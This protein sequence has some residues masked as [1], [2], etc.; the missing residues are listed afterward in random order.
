MSNKQISELLKKVASAYAIKNEKKFFFQIIAYQKAADAI[1]NSQSQIVNLYKKGQLESL[2]GV[3]PSIKAHLEELLRTGEVKQFNWVFEDIPDSVFPLLKVSGFGPK[4]AYKLATY[5][6]LNNT[7][8]AIDEL[9]KAANSNKISQIEGFGEKSQQEILRAIEEF[10]KGNTKEKKMNLSI[11]TEVSEKIISYLKESKDVLRVETLGSLR[12]SKETIKDIDIA[13]STNNPKKV[14]KHF[15]SYPYSEKTIEEGV[16]SASIAAFGGKQIDLMTQS[17]DGFGS[18]MQHFTGSKNHNIK[19]REYALKKGLSLS[20]Y[21]IKKNK[22]LIKFK[23]EE[24]F[25]NALKMQWIPPEMREDGGEIE[26]A[27]KNKLPKLIE[28]K[29]LKGDL[30]IHSNYSIEPSHDL[31]KDTMERILETAIKMKYE[32]IAFSE[33]NP[34]V[35]KHTNKSVYEILSRR[36]LKI[37]QLYSNI[38]SVRLIKLLEIDILANGELA[39]DNRSIDLLDGFIASIHSSFNASQEDMTK[40]I[41]NALSHPK[42]KILGH[43]TGRII[44]QR[45]GYK[46]NWDKIFD[47]CKKNN[48]ALEINS[49][50]SRLDIN[51]K[52]IREAIQNKVKLVINSDSHAAW[53]MTMLKYGVANARRGWAKKENILNTLPYDKF[54]EWLKK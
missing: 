6:H 14:I 52:L 53:Q 4:K 25:Y 43:P 50:P 49:W 39:I 34:S 3:G 7:E 9:E 8:T 44:N 16:I 28:L 42:A 10:K 51:D 21:G 41:L 15:I 12:R 40:R 18:L 24:N 37:E 1:E 46:L 54:I 48:K 32:Y 5:L 20:E 26:L 29:D 30:H 33:H 47:F 23:T 13:V 31:G 17:P 36:S 45:E 22:K 38:K 35:S 19:L 27:L 11:A 2:P